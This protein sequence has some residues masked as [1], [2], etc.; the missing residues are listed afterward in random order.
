MQAPRR[1]LTFYTHGD[2]TFEK[3]YASISYLVED[4]H[5]LVLS[6]PTLTFATVSYLALC[7]QRGWITDLILSTSKD[8]SALI[9]QYLSPYKSHVL[10]AAHN[11]VTDLS[12]HMVIYTKK[13]SLSLAGPMIETRLQG[14]SLVSYSLLYCPRIDVVTSQPWA[15]SLLNILLKLTEKRM[16]R[17]FRSC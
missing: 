2:V 5:I 12:S 17:I 13:Q 7:F 14:V 9:E 15:N 4:S 16:K 8:V 6:M 10:Y 11:N 1:A 3:F